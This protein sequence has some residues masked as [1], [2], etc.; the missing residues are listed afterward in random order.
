MQKALDDL[1][2]AGGHTVVLVA[3]RLSTVVNAHQIVVMDHG[4]VSLGLGLGLGFVWADPDPDPEPN[5]VVEQGTHEA[6]LRREGVYASLVA[7]QL[8]KQ[9]EQIE[10]DAAAASAK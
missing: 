10:T 6:L 5:Q 4:Q 8:Q 1:I 2:W 7:T 9:R 3:H